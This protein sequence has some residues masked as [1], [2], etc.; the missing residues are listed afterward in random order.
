MSRTDNARAWVLVAP[1]ALLLTVLMLLPF[2]ATVHKAL[3][4]VPSV[5][6]TLLSDP[7]KALAEPLSAKNFTVI[8]AD[9]DSRK[10]VATTVLVAATVATLL[11]AVSM[12][13]GYHI[14]RGRR[15]SG[16]VNAIVTF[17]SL[18]PG[19]TIVFGILWLFGPTGP[20]N[21][22]LWRTLGIVAEPIAFTGTMAA[23]IVGDMALFSTI[24]VRMVASVY[25]MIDP[26][27]EQA[28]ESLGARD[29]QT[30]RFVVWPL[31]LPGLAAAWI[32][33]FFRT[34]AAYVAALVLGGGTR[35]VVVIPLDI[36]LQINSLGV[37]GSIGAAAALAVVLVGTTLV[38]RAVF[39]LIMRRAFR[40][41]M[42]TEVL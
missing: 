24:A 15:W 29:S 40:D 36:Y 4:T 1:Y 6:F 26:V 30:F 16:T 9:S 35:G 33:L 21:T 41:R 42:G 5:S 11:C 25:E 22:L 18:A 7:I 20:I 32:F 28:S 23:V 14:A 38:G 2:A 8:A 3:S 34:M 31:L 17:P 19:V 13:V 27:L 10:V 12:F 39:L 37:G